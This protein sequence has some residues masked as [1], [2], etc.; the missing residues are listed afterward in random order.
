MTEQ[1]G[2]VRD[3]KTSVREERGGNKLKNE[4]LWEDGGE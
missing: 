1:D 3:W 4:G 2:S